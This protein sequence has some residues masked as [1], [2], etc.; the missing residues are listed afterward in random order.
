[1]S[2]QKYAQIPGR[3]TN[4][5]PIT[6]ENGTEVAQKPSAVAMGQIPSNVS[7]VMTPEGQAQERADY[8]ATRGRS[9]APQ[10]I[11]MPNTDA[12]PA[13]DLIVGD[14]TIRRSLVGGFERSFTK[15]PSDFDVFKG[16]DLIHPS[17]AVG[18]IYD[19]LLALQDDE[20]KPKA[21]K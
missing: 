21:K 15:N 1:M 3:K 18:A 12:D 5:F 14:V 6:I 20:P 8:L 16:E 7:D 19:A 4:A 11:Q 13:Q 10:S 9:H 2:E 17:K